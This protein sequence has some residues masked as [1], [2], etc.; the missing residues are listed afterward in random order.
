[1]ID[2]KESVNDYLRRMLKADK[3]GIP[4]NWKEA[5]FEIANLASNYIEMQAHIMKAMREEEQ[6]KEGY[7][8]DGE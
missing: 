1:M 4:V 7:K 3:E 5:A 8:R 6:K 2:G